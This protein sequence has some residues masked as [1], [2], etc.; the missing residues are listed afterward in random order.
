MELCGSF[1][2][3]GFGQ[4]VSPASQPIPT[5]VC[6][7]RSQGY[8]SKMEFRELICPRLS[9]SQTLSS[10]APPAAVARAPVDFESVAATVAG[11][12]SFPGE[13]VARPKLRSERR[14]LK[15]GAVGD[16]ALLHSRICAAGSVHPQRSS[17]SSDSDTT[18][19]CCKKPRM[20]RPNTTSGR[21]AGSPVLSRRPG[22]ALEPRMLAHVYLSE[23]LKGV[24][25]KVFSLHVV[26]FWVITK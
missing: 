10:V 17:I 13:T 8:A 25:W 4:S 14:R 16:R 12:D 22:G 18:T 9:P 1:F 15:D 2:R 21:H 7:A 3:N 26:S 5:R 24:L 23:F 20:Q 11:V 6:R 19:P